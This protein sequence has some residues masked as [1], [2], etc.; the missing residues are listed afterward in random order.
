MA[1]A[2][3]KVKKRVTKT[4]NPLASFIK[5][6]YRSKSVLAAKKRLATAE[7]MYKAAVKASKSTAKKKRKIVKK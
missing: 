6:V 2:K 3:K 7:R 1:V 4:K 5:A